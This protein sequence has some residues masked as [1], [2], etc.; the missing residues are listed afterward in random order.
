MTADQ[1]VPRPVEYPVMG[2]SR[3]DGCV[4]FL[5]LLIIRGLVCMALESS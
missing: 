1:I 4:L 5:V 2:Y 3:P